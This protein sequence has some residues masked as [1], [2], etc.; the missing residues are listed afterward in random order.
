MVKINK[1]TEQGNIVKMATYA[2]NDK[3]ACLTDYIITYVLKRKSEL[4]SEELRKSIQNS[5][6]E[7]KGTFIY[8]VNGNCYGDVYV[9]IQDKN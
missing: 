1:I 7:G 6:H 8:Y 9:A 3:K 2:G 5:L 4:L